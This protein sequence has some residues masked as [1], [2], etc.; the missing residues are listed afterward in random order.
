MKMSVNIHKLIAKSDSERLMV[1]KMNE[2]AQEGLE[3]S[4]KSGRTMV[5]KEKRGTKRK[6]ISQSH[7]GAC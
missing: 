5:Y 6:P 2:E 4:L 7:C 1:I 3:L